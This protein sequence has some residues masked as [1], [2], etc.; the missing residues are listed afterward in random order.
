MCFYFL[1]IV[2]GGAVGG[3]LAWRLS[4]STT[5]TVSLL[6]RST[7]D[8]IK[9]HGIPITSLQYG[10]ATY[11]PESLYRTIDDAIAHATS[12]DYVLVALK[13]L[14]NIYDSS[15]VISKA[16]G[17]GTMILLF[18]NG[19][20]VEEPFLKRFGKG[21]PVVS[22]V[23]F[24]SV[25][26]ENREEEGSGLGGWRL[27][28]GGFTMVVAGFAN[29][30]HTNED[31]QK[32]HNLFAEFQHSG[33]IDCLIKSDI[34]AYRWQKQ[35]L[36]GSTNPVSVLSR[37]S[38]QEMV[39]HKRYRRMLKDVMAEIFAVAESV[40]KGKLPGT[41][42]ILDP[43]AAIR[44]IEGIEAPVYTSMLEDALNKR[45]METEVIL[46]NPID[47]A[48]KHGVAVPHMRALYESLLKIEQAYKK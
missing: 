27:R 2:G 5:H 24:V 28:H 44:Y 30:Q 19:I 17:P 13:A 3:L 46:K 33:G 48:E 47:L 12:F 7:Y 8:Q 26:K 29:E 22:C 9:S 36:N 32:L 23:S 41:N 10:N 4:H 38:C 37:L 35:I 34:Q 14:P 16:V 31:L 20:G 43:P 25:C 42:G 21:N 6:C 11:H 45:H 40:I 39:R 15:E 1:N 18:Q